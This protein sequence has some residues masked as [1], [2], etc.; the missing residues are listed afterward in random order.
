MEV[1]EEWPQICPCCNISIPN[2]VR[3]P[4]YYNIYVSTEL[5]QYI[6]V[7]DISQT[8]KKAYSKSGRI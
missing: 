1:D 7:F 8:G 5:T 2:Q 4:G 3:R 6:G